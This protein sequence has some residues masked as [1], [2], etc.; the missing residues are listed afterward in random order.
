[1]NNLICCIC[2]TK[3]TYRFYNFKHTNDD[4]MNK[5][6]INFCD[7]HNFI[8]ITED[9]KQCDKEYH[10]HTQS[11]NENTMRLFFWSQYNPNACINI[12][13]KNMQ[14]GET[15]LNT[16]V[17][18]NQ[19]NIRLY[20]FAVLA[21]KDIMRVHDYNIW[22]NFTWIDIHGNIR[23]A[24]HDMIRGDFR[25]IKNMCNNKIY[26]VCHN[27]ISDHDCEY[28]EYIYFPSC[29]KQYE[30]Y[31]KCNYCGTSFSEKKCVMH[32]KE[33]LGQISMCCCCMKIKQ[34]VTELSYV[35]NIC[36]SF[37]KYFDQINK[38]LSKDC[39]NVVTEYIFDKKI[40]DIFPQRAKSIHV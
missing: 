37:D 17:N 20:F 35:E 5:F 28:D 14:L 18:M 12:M 29:E 32:D 33:S 25:S 30:N 22:S 23:H 34:I 19:V 40:I 31:H 6:E 36:R 10:Y 4:F 3:A 16:L 7:S 2:G 8:H 27:I 38:W 1:M 26:V 13:L 24:F 9:Q 15:L 11:D 39:V 21:L